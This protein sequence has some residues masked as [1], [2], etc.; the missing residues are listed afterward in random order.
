MHWKSHVCST[1]TDISIQS[2]NLKWMLWKFSFECEQK[3]PRRKTNDWAHTYSIA[4]LTIE[5][6]KGCRNVKC[7][8][9]Y[10]LQ[11]QI[12]YLMLR[13]MH[14]NKQLTNKIIV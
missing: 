3:T 6:K 4:Y 14:Y 8:S 9:K 11:A 1:N 5:C 7:L 13:K 10:L 12:E 2:C